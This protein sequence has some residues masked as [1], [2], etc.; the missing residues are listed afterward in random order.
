MRSTYDIIIVGGGITGAALAY[1]LS[2]A[3]RRVAVLD[4]LTP[5]NMASRTNVGLIWC[6]SKFLHL[7]D[8]A[9]WGFLSS[10]LFPELVDELQRLTGMHI[11]VNFT[12]GLI[13]CLGEEG[14]AKRGDYIDKLREALGTYRG[15]M[16]DRAELET[17]LPRIAFGPEVVGAAWCEEDGVIEPLTLLRAFRAA[18]PRA[19]VD[20]VQAGVCDVRPSAGGYTLRTSKGDYACERLVLA[21]GLGNRRLAGFA[22]PSLPV[23]ADKGQVLLVERLP[24][25]M[26]IPLLGVT[27]TF[28]GTVVVGFR[29]EKV[30]HDTRVDPRAVA[31]EGAWALRVWPE[32][33][34]RRIIR[35]WT[36]L[37]V[38]PDDNMAIYS[39]LPGHPNAILVNTHSAVTMAAA[40]ARLL[41]P[42][43]LGGE[44]PETARGMTL[45]RFGHAC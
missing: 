3:G 34:A 42:F 10:R 29:H 35:T 27:Q 15:H 1:G 8:Y 18:L 32:L 9:R 11:P 22:M 38:M 31:G 6:Q 7:P 19:G 21:A 17:K 33:G 30:G 23:F 26:P 12:G 16:I 13:P 36:G 24:Q 20:L 37:R 44:L 2:G 25:V 39:P 45:R 43:L 5:A 41:P 40:H 14:Y 4:E 28:G